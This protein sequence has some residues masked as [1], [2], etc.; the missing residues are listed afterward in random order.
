MEL[1]IQMKAQLSEARAQLALERE[2]RQ[3]EEEERKKGDVAVGE[4]AELGIRLAELEAELEALK[5][6]GKKDLPRPPEAKSPLTY[7][8]LH[9]DD[10]DDDKLNANI[11]ALC[12]GL[13]DNR[14]L[15]PS[16]DRNRLLCRTANRLNAAVSQ[17]TVEL[18]LTEDQGAE[19]LK[20]PL[21]SSD[22]PTPMEGTSPDSLEDST[23]EEL[24][25]T[26]ACPESPA[27]AD[28]AREVERLREEKTMEALRA[29][30][31]QA[32]LEALQSQVGGKSL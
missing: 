9:D 15:L 11:A 6:N 31:C 12:P 3:R 2:E 23:A 32:K 28:L 5:R 14:T 18:I 24:S 20:L 7:L 21:L 29:E 19:L 17:T 8:T 27:P 30:Q 1:N 26:P 16:P 25:R 10:D 4:K 22:G 13:D